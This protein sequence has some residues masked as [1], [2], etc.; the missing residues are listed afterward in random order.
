MGIIYKVTNKANGKVYIGQTVLSLKIRWALHISARSGCRYL[1]R[2]IKKYGASAFSIE[3]IDAAETIEEL[4]AKEIFWIARYDSA[5][6][7]KGY[8]LM[9]GGGSNGHHSQETKEIC[10][11]KSAA[12]WRDDKYRARVLPKIIASRKTPEFREG[13]SNERK[14]NWRDT[15]YRDAMEQKMSSAEY[16]EKQSDT[17]KRKYSDAEYKA[18]WIIANRE[19]HGE[20]IECVETGKVFSSIGEAAAFIGSSDTSIRKVLHGKRKTAGGYHWRLA[21]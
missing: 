7:K 2:A 3:Q 9:S 10:R 13:R 14:A 5:N 17:K 12:M 18:R 6:P 1:S 20:K 15:Q 16:R 11:I 4:N 21:I 8:N 19:K